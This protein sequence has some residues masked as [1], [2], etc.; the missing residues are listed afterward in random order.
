[1]GT[2]IARVIYRTGAFET[3]T[4][5]STADVERK[6]STRQAAHVIGWNSGG[7][8]DTKYRRM[9][10]ASERRKLLASLNHS[11]CGIA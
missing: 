3:V 4:G 10:T 6:L 5:R 11:L 8:G 9:S 7:G 1:M 2:T